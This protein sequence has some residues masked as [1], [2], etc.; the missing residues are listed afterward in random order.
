MGVVV[1]RQRAER[2]SG[3]R[4]LLSAETNIPID[5]IFD[6]QGSRMVTGEERSQ[7]IEVA[8]PS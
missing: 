5:I 2:R 1:G 7:C 6:D 8:Q 4:Y 3:D